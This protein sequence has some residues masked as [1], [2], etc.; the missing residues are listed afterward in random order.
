M[1]Y[2]RFKDSKGNIHVV[3]EGEPYKRLP[4]WEE[5]PP[6]F[7]DEQVFNDSVGKLAKYVGISV[8]EAITRLTKA[9]N[10]PK[11]A[12]CQKRSMILQEMGKIG[13]IETAKRLRATFKKDQKE[14]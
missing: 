13:W 1:A 7:D 6:S 5:L 3:P 4:D 2:I 11:C 14:Q 10:I 8:D 12:A 9:L